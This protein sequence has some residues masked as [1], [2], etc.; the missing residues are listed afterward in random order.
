MLVGIGRMGKGMKYR[1]LRDN[2]I[3]G[4]DW[5]HSHHFLCLRLL[6]FVGWVAWGHDFEGLRLKAAMFYFMLLV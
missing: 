6:A 3:F 5:I 4:G 2:A 1:L